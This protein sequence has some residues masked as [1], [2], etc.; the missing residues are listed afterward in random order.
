MSYAI[1]A[2]LQSAIYARLT[3]DAA[4]DALVSGAIYDVPPSGGLPPLYVTLGAE[5]VRDAGD[6]TG[7]GADH[8]L[9]IAVVCETGGFAAAKTAAGAVSDALTAAP[10][11]LSRGRVVGLWFRRATAERIGTGNGRQI[12][13]TFRARVED[14]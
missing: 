3:G 7:D 4:L 10:L 6:K 13:L 14:L 12:T 1:A 5:R 11:T 9:T 8:D 2:A